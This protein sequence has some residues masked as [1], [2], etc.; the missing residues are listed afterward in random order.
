VFFPFPCPPTIPP[1]HLCLLS[2]VLSLLPFDVEGE[3]R[4]EMGGHRLEGV[5]VQ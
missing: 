3:R 1:G 4:G 5:P 2:I